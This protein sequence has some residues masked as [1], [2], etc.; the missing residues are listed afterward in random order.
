MSNYTYTTTSLEGSLAPHSCM[1][2]GGPIS[3]S[4]NGSPVLDEHHAFVPNIPNAGQVAAG[5]AL[6]AMT[7]GNIA[8]A[9]RPIDT[10]VYGP[11][12]TTL[13]GSDGDV[14]PTDSISV[15]AGSSL[16]R[17]GGAWVVRSP[18]PAF[19]PM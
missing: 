3:S 16:V 4:A 12:N 7:A 14:H 9:T 15:P 11:A 5:V 13:L 17:Q 18:D 19:C 6:F 2:I 8:P 1:R 10:V